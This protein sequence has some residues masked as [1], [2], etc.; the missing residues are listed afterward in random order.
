MEPPISLHQMNGGRSCMAM[1][2]RKSIPG[3][4][5]PIGVM[6]GVGV[7]EGSPLLAPSFLS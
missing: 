7:M 6:E 2:W 4:S 5:F 3:P 1:G